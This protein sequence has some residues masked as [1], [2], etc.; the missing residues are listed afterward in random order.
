ML[1]WFLQVPG[2]SHQVFPLLRGSPGV[3]TKTPLL[4]L[5]LVLFLGIFDLLFPHRA[6]LLG[7]IASGPSFVFHLILLSTRCHPEPSVRKL[8]M[9][10]F[11]HPDLCLLHIPPS[12]LCGSASFPRGFGPPPGGLSASFAGGL[13]LPGALSASFASCFAIFGGLTASFGASSRGDLLHGDSPTLTPVFST[14]RSLASF[15]PSFFSYPWILLSLSLSLFLQLSIRILGPP[16]HFFMVPPLLVLQEQW[17]LDWL[18]R[19]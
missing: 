8:T 3:R 9:S 6:N 19:L 16:Q 1:P 4:L 10:I 17:P 15:V 2:S 13:P 7:G 5:V 18:K 12:V 14:L 11:V